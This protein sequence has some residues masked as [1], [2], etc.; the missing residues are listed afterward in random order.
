[1]NSYKP[2][3]IIVQ[4]T[5][6]IWE[7][8]PEPCL[9]DILKAKIAYYGDTDAANE[10]AHQEYHRQ[11]KEYEKIPKG[12]YIMGCDP[13]TDDTIITKDGKP[14]TPAEKLKSEDLKH[15]SSQG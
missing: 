3:G 10:F 8:V 13:I 11:M 14:L 2:H 5:I 1:M 15:H 6:E 4:G 9:V 12:K 7:K